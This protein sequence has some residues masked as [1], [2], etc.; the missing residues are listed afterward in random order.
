MGRGEVVPNP[1]GSPTPP[2]WPNGP[3]RALGRW[4]PSSR[5][6]LGLAP[7]KPFRDSEV[8]VGVVCCRAGW[9]GGRVFAPMAD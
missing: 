7:D 6:G 4:R 2:T 8:A 3:W 5:R 1:S 9:G